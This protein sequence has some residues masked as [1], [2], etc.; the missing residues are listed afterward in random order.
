MVISP[1]SVVDAGVPAA[2]GA[3]DMVSGGNGEEGDGGAEEEEE[4]KE[5]RRGQHYEREGGRLEISPR[6]E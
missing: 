1:E 5:T 3:D 6:L 4:G 2:V